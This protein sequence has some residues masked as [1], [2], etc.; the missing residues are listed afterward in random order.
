MTCSSC[1]K[2]SNKTIH[3][4]KWEY[5]IYWLDLPKLLLLYVI[6]YHYFAK[7]LGFES[8]LVPIAPKCYQYY[9]LFYQWF[10]L[11]QSWFCRIESIR[12]CSN[13][14]KVKG[15]FRKRQ[16]KTTGILVGIILVFVLCHVFRLAIQVSFIKR[17]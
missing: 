15:V 5:L 6:R 14:N 16:D 3:P 9:I 17:S 11:N 10:Y 1:Q 4:L 2:S 13:D 12:R 7:V 8:Y